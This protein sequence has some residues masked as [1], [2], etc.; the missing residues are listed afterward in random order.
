VLLR[1]L[2]SVG[3]MAAKKT[4]P[5]TLGWLR[6]PVSVH[7]NRRERTQEGIRLG[8]NP[9][10]LTLPWVDVLAVQSTSGKPVA[11]WFCH[12]AHAVTLGGDSL[13][14]SAD[15]PGYA[16]RA[17]QGAEPGTTALFAQGCCGN[18]NSHPRGTFEIAERQGWVMGGA[19]IK[20]AALAEQSADVILD[21]A[22]QVV[23]LPLQ[24]PPPV[25]EAERLLAA[26]QASRDRA[27][28][29]T[30]Y[31]MRKTLDGYVRW[32]EDLV[33]MARRGA[34]GMTIP[35]EVHAVRIGEGVVVGLPGEVFAEYAINIAERSPARQTVVTAYTNGNFGYVPTEAAF[36]E[37]GYEVDH[38]YYFYLPT[39][40]TPDCERLVL[41]AA[42]GLVG[43][44]FD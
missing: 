15:W 17:V 9:E 40:L 13:L 4:E 27:G 5:A 20:A 18:L 22:A 10:G 38:A 28:D 3:I 1:K 44:L 12:A 19:V 29:D 31:Q 7:V 14:I 36:A 34:T 21:H 41:D 35:F 26:H 11:R 2:A 25:E 42:E 6:E 23:N 8:H 24:D 30:A 33:D 37:G 16:Q 39:M 43:S 32:A